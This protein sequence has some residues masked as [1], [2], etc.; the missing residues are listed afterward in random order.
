MK[1]LWIAIVEHAEVPGAIPVIFYQAEEPTHKQIE[2]HFPGIKGK[3][4]EVETL[5]FLDPVRLAKGALQEP[6]K[7]FARDLLR[8][9]A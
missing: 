1:Q 3:D 9:P 4:L 8:E 7:E 6:L 2:E 5:V